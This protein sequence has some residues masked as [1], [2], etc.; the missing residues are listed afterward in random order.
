MHYF[1]LNRRKEKKGPYSE[2]QLRG[3]WE[4]GK[5]PAG[6]LCCT[7][8]MKKWK[9]IEKFENIVKEEELPEPKPE[10]DTSAPPVAGEEYDESGKLVSKLFRNLSDGTL[11]YEERYKYH[12]N[13]KLI[14]SSKHI[15]YE[16]YKDDVVEVVHYEVDGTFAERSVFVYESPEY[17]IEKITYDNDGREISRLNYAFPAFRVTW[18]IL[19]GLIGLAACIFAFMWWISTGVE[20]AG[21]PMKRFFPGT[22]IEGIGAGFKW[23]INFFHTVFIGI[24]TGVPSI[25]C[26]IIMLA[27]ATRNKCNNFVYWYADLFEEI[28][29]SIAGAAVAM[30]TMEL[31]IRKEWVVG[32]NGPAHFVFEPKYLLTLLFISLAMHCLHWSVSPREKGTVRSNYQSQEDEVFRKRTVANRLFRGALDDDMLVFL[33][34]GAVFGL[35]IVLGFT[36]FTSATFTFL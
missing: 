28:A 9:P 8:G 7:K 10:P 3:H 27:T 32:P 6:I 4:S 23:F 31:F 20:H 26:G 18:G 21:D 22:E 19:S 34:G 29:M 25:I 13:G 16:K 35:L 11:A 12:E 14:Q 5:I 36:I 24:F 2:E 1:L 30:L 17:V 33:F 15:P